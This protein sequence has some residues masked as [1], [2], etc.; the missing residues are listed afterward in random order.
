MQLTIILN[1]LFQFLTVL[2]AK[3]Y[4]RTSCEKIKLHREKSINLGKVRSVNSFDIKIKN[5]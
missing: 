4:L 5:R 2:T 3:I 1:I